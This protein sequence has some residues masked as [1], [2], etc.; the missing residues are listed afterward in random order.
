MKKTLLIALAFFGTLSLQAGADAETIF[1]SNCA[2]CHMK[3]PM[4]DKQKMMQMSREERMSM[5]QKMMENMKAPP[6]SKVSAKLKNDFKTKEAFVSFVKDYIVTPSK[7]KSHCMPMALERFGVMPPMGKG[8][9]ETELNNIAN[10]LYDSFDSKWD[11]DDKGMLCNMNGKKGMGQG[12]MKCGQGKCGGG[13]G[14][15][16]PEAETKSMKC[17]AGKCGSK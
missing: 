10:W 1:N 14:K 13:M 17:Q 2:V 6:M 11:A 5:K 3:K 4:M 9:S 7:E 15:K 12:G 8:L 16:K